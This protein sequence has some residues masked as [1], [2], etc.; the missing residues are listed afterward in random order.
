M[1]KFRLTPV[2]LIV[3][4]VCGGLGWVVRYLVIEPAEMGAACERAVLWWCPIR[5]NF[6][7]F[8]QAF[9]MAWAAL[10]LAGLAIVLPR[11]FAPPA[12]IAAMAVAGLGLVLYNTAGAAAALVLALIRA[13]WLD[14]A[15]T[16]AQRA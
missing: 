10:I 5:L 15:S 7:Y 1:K 11:R 13:A 4:L 16:A 14:R 8:H 6:I 3:A 9:G 12:V 2:S